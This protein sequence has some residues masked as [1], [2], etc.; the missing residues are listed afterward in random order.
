[1]NNYT[2]LLL[3]PDYVASQLDPST[4]LAHVVAN[5]APTPFKPPGKKSV[6]MTAPTKTSKPRPT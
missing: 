1:M 5:G 6:P 3:R 4:Y 2:V